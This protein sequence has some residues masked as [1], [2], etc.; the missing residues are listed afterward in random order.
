ML[1]RKLSKRGFSLIE[2][3]VA[4]VILALAIFGI[5]HAYSVG[6]MGMADARARTVATNY[7]REAMEDIKNMDFG[8]IVPQGS[9]VTVNGITYNRQIIVQENPNIKR[10]ITTVTWKDRNLN[11]KTVEADMLVH[12]IETTAGDATKIMLIA[13]PYNILTINYDDTIGVYENES[14]IIAVVK[15]AKGNTV[16]NYSGEITFLI[17]DLNSSGS[18]NLSTSSVSVN[19]GIATTTFT[20]SIT[21]KGEVII[22]A[23]ANE[24]ADDSVTIK[25]T[26]PGEPVKI[27][28][29]N[30]I[31]G[32]E[33]LFMTPGSE[34]TITA[35]IVD[36]GGKKV[37]DAN[38]EIFFEVYSGPGSLSTPT[39]FPA[40]NGV[41]NIILTSND[42]PGG[43]ITVTASASGLEP[44]VVDVITGGKIYL[45]TSSTT[46]PVNEKSEIIVTTKDVNGVPINYIGTI[47][48]SVEST[49]GGLGTLFPN[50]ITFDGST[51][52][53]SVIFTAAISEG[54]VNVIAYEDPYVILT[55]SEPLS[56]TVTTALVPDHI[57]VYANP[58]S[59]QVGGTESSTINARVKTADNITITSYTDTIVFTTTKG[60]FSNENTT[61]STGDEGVTYKDGVAIVELY[62]PDNSGTA[63]ISVASIYN[64]NEISGSTEVGF[65]IDADYIQLIANPQHIEVISGNPNA[66]IITATIKDE[67]YNNTIYGYDGKV[68]FSIVSGDAKFAL[69][70]S[71]IIT[72]VNGEAQI[73]LQSG[74]SSGTVRV[75]ATSS[76][77]NK[78]GVKTD[79]EGYLNIP[80]GISLTLEESS[81]D[82]LEVNTVSFNIII[83]GA[84]LTLEQMQ[85]FWDSPT[86]ETLNRIE[87]KSPS[88]AGSIIVYDTDIDFP[89]SPPASSGEIINVTDN[90]LSTGISNIKMY[91]STD[92]DVKNILDVTFNPNSGDY[93]LHLKP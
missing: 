74:N 44:G 45:S 86:D 93:L 25:I 23:S 20:A 38:N 49:D 14:I 13:N 7:A 87:I 9:S 52:S 57:E 16:S 53:I 11:T 65:Y 17:D 36:A 6:F 47:K 31:L 54:G 92:M 34:S 91:F 29:T 30:S 83:I 62:P 75:K 85:V 41:A 50:P 82:Y 35:T 51:S 3:M 22:I 78:E 73:L 10:V 89:D 24:L 76:Y 26:D 84:S 1:N 42:P 71:T 60:T 4:V 48:F 68:K 80:V 28:L 90:T 81:V 39:T 79:I 32:V 55:D 18:G 2:L 58:S 59:I 69:T 5:F 70:G 88:T 21:G 56:L 63:I 8:E 72:V 77:K 37:D 43:T 19:K 67:E 61:I 66:C 12:F 40:S 15:D 33:T 46:V 64:G 27:N